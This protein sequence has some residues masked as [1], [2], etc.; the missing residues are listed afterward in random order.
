MDEPVDAKP[1]EKSIIFGAVKSPPAPWV[2]IRSVEGGGDN[3]DVGPSLTETWTLRL[4][5]M[6]LD[7]PGILKDVKDGTSSFFGDDG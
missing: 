7:F 3:R 2:K 1:Y 5:G 6:G 4:H